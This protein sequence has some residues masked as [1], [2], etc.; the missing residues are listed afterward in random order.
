MC[1]FFFLGFF[2]NVKIWRLPLNFYLI[3]SQI[4]TWTLRQQI[5][6]C[7]NLDRLS[8]PQ[9][10]LLTWS[11]TVA[12]PGR[13][14]FLS[15]CVQKATSS[16]SHTFSCL[17]TTA[18]KPPITAAAVSS[19]FVILTAFVFTPTDES[20]CK[21]NKKK[22]ASALIRGAMGVCQ[23]APEV[24]SKGSVWRH[25]TLTQPQGCLQRHIRCEC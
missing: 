17:L 13:L 19:I 22:G 1:M 4:S 14:T 15:Q 12:I 16:W 9:F 11:W 21:H 3:F 7:Q 25:P 23:R 10:Q 8:C 5:I 20:P 6:T 24:A 2:F 18:W